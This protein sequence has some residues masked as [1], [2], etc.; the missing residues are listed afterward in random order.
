M[1]HTHG[2]TLKG[3]KRKKKMTRRKSILFSSLVAVAFVGSAA[4]QAVYAEEPEFYTISGRIVD[5]EH[6]PIAKAEVKLV[7]EKGE[8]I[9]TVDSGMDGMFELEHKP[10]KKCTLEVIPEGGSGLAS[11]LIEAVPGEA[12]RSVIVELHKGVEV[13]GRISRDGRGL[14]GLIVKVSPVKAANESSSVHGGGYAIT[15]RDGQ[16][17]FILTPGQKR[18]N[19]RN[20][21]YSELMA[22]YATN[23]TVRDSMELPE[24]SLPPKETHK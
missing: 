7:S 24:V 1:R 11:A 21:R 5:V 4:L 19:I 20:D 2:Y 8:I 23:I 12:N 18:L 14:K 6:K 16:Y 10:T 13:K 9:K 15:G 17:R 22:Q 3:L